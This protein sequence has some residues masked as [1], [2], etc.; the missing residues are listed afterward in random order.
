MQSARG[1]SGTVE[2]PIQ[3][4]SVSSKICWTRVKEHSHEESALLCTAQQRGAYAE[5]KYM[6]RYWLSMTEERRFD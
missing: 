4:I 1:W 5:E 3:P 2:E 6:L